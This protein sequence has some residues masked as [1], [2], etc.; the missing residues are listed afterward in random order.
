MPRPMR[1]SP[2]RPLVAAIP[3]VMGVMVPV[4][5]PMMVAEVGA[6]AYAEI[7]ARLNSVWQESR[8]TQQYYC[9]QA[10]SC[11]FHFRLTGDKPSH[12]ISLRPCIIISHQEHDVKIIAAPVRR[13]CRP[14]FPMRRYSKIAPVEASEAVLAVMA[15]SSGEKSSASVFSRVSRQNTMAVTNILPA[16]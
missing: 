6:E 16:G 9:H 10:K 3:P 14:G 4:V 8:R 7:D 5:I 15:S 11:G 1:M 12:L 13:R 2:P